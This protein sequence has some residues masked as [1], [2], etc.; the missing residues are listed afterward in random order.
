MHANAILTYISAIVKF[1]RVRRG[2]SD[3]PLHTLLHCGL[4]T[5]ILH[6]KYHQMLR[7]M[8][9]QNSKFKI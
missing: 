4:S 2:G 6:A 1:G 7:Y 8:L 9:D 5:A 3:Y